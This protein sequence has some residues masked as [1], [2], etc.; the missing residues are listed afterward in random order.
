M[1]LFYDNF[2]CSVEHK[3]K[4]SDWFRTRSGVGEGCVMSGFLFLLLINWTMQQV[5]KRKRG[6]NWGGF[7]DSKI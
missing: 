1:K 7:R 5:T 3:G 6:I 4:Q 2:N